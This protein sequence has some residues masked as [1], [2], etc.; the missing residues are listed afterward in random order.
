MKIQGLGQPIPQQPKVKQASSSTELSTATQAPKGVVPWAVMDEK[1]VEKL[2]YDQNI[3]SGG[4][5]VSHYQDVANQLKRQQ[6]N[7]M[8]GID[9]FA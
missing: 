7:E 9:L 6:V 8:F 2:R 3:G 4:E 1:S 5:A